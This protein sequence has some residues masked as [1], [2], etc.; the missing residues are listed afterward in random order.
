MSYYK[1]KHFYT[2]LEKIIPAT[3]IV[4]KF[5]IPYDNKVVENY[6]K[7]E[8]PIVKSPKKDIIKTKS[9]DPNIWGNGLWL[10][11]HLGAA[12]YPDKA[13]PGAKERMKN[14]ILGL[15]FILPC[16]NCFNHALNYVESHKEKLNDIC[17][18]K[19]KLFSFFN[20][21]HNMVN[22]RLNKEE[23]SLGDAKEKFW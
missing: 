14:F 22:K 17:S 10:V 21:F 8:N 6:V 12:N 3:N 15:P 20:K 23:M 4:E 19:D 13:S 1:S 16:E 7:K 5:I 9:V 18:G 11:L 2:N